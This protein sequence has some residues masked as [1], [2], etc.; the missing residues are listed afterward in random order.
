MDFESKIH[1]MLDE[2]GYPKEAADCI[3]KYSI[4]ERYFKKIYEQGVKDGKANK[5]QYLSDGS[6][7]L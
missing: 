1:A 6:L 4:I 7:K 3:S 5:L 2:I